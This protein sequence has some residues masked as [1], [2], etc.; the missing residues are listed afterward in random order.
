M[1]FDGFPPGG[2]TFLANL[3][4]NNNKVWFERNKNRYQQDLLA[5]AQGFVAAMGEALQTLVPEIQYDTRA[6]GSGSLMRIYRDVR[7]SV[8]VA[9]LAHQ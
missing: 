5:P 7:F 4:Q 1:S 9:Q 3:E 2:L 8:R 6:N